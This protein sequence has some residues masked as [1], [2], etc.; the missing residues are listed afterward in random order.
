MKSIITLFMFI[1]SLAHCA[2]SAYAQ[3]SI[4]V[5]GK[6]YEGSIQGMATMTIDFQSEGKAVFTM[7]VFGNKESKDV[8]YE[9]NGNQIVVHA[10]N[11]DMTFSQSD[12]N[13]LTT[14]VKGTT[15]RLTCQTPNED[16]EKLDEVAN[17]VFSGEFGNNGHLTLS[18]SN[19]GFVSVTVLTNNQ[20]QEENWPY[21]QEGDTIILTEPLGRKI[22]LTLNG[23]NDLKGL[24]TIVNVTLALIR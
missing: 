3:D 22:K 15:V 18:F 19:N 7:S 20:R 11:G 21:I 17:H 2:I 12:T 9:Q 13:V 4:P 14:N 10:R 8:T 5:Q 24:F 16:S 6:E 23:N 1:L